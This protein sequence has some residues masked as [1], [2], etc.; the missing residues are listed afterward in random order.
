MISFMV[1][2]SHFF[3]YCFLSHF[4]YSVCI[5]QFCCFFLLI[6]FHSFSFLY[7]VETLTFKLLK[8]EVEISFLVP[9]LVFSD[10][11]YMILYDLT[12]AHA[13]IPYVRAYSIRQQVSNN[14]SLTPNL[15]FSNLILCPN[16]ICFPDIF[17]LLPL[18]TTKQVEMDSRHNVMFA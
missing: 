10:W 14:F 2:L 13:S 8:L 11:S 12:F 17:L 5:V 18:Y 16:S 15:L 3:I 7:F 4:F 1:L 6:F 9:L